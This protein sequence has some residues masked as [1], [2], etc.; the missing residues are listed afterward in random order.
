MGLRW[1]CVCVGGL[2]RGTRAEVRERLSHRR[3]QKGPGPGEGESEGRLRCSAGALA[4]LHTRA[5]EAVAELVRRTRP[6]ER[7]E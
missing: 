1:G 4:L 6:V 2:A 5:V 7:C 3:A